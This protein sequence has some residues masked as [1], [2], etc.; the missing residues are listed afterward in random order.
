[1]RKL[2]FLLLAISWTFLLVTWA[3]PP[4]PRFELLTEQGDEWKRWEAWHDRET[5]REYVCRVFHGSMT[6]YSA[7]SQQ[8]GWCEFTGRVWK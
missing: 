7:G 6:G 1:M 5:G 8:Q 3:Q 4:K 2:F